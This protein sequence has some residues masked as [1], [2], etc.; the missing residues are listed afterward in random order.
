M[1]HQER[2]PTSGARGIPQ[3]DEAAIGSVLQ[4]ADVIRTM[5]QVL[6]EF[7]KGRIAQPARRLFPTP[8]HGGFLGAMPAAAAHAVGAKLVTFF[9]HNAERNLHTHNASIVLFR[10]ETGEPIA[11]LDGRLITEMRTAAVTAAY[12]DAVAPAEVGSLA[13]LGAG[14]QARAHLEALACV[15]T[16]PDI[17][18]WNRTRSRA[19]AL[20]A[21]VGGR[22]LDARDAVHG[23]DIVIVCTA[24]PDPVLDGAWLKPGAKV[25]SVG[26]RGPDGAELDAATMAHTVIVDSREGAATESGNVRRYNAHIFAELGEVL[27][28]DKV[29]DPRATVVF[30]SIGMACEDIAAA[31]LA[32]ECLTR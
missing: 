16:I 19:E 5:R 8:V 14:V 22:A 15:R 29:P 30:D 21:A 26:W 4:M 13:I 31:S 2:E 7:S 25:A 11:L 32:Y 23:A 12:V 1:E 10:P 17:R 18:I 9:P 24:S 20:A 28:G 3:F 27:A 6:I